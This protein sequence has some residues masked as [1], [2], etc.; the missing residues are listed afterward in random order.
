MR[1]TVILLCAILLSGFALRAQSD[2]FES[3][4]NQP[5]FGAR[6]SLD[7]SCPTDIT[8]GKFGFDAFSNAAGFEIGGIYN[9][10]LWKNLYFE[11]GLSLYYNTM[12]LSD[13]YIDAAVGD[14]TAIDKASGSVRRLGFR[15]PGCRL[16]FRFRAGS[17]IGIHRPCYLGGSS[18]PNTR[19][20]QRCRCKCIEKLQLL[21]RRRSV[22]ACRC[23]LALRCRRH[24]G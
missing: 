3:C 4:D 1:K 13:T 12:K 6:L 5:Y 14:V 22:Q 11:P 8:E 7:V 9:I 17:Y 18:R 16:S 19:Q 20:G 23:R 21:C 24:M 15:A 10:P 2:I